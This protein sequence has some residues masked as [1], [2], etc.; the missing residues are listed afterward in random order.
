MKN[1]V[2]RKRAHKE[3][4][5]EERGWRRG[6]RKKGLKGK[7]VRRMRMEKKGLNVE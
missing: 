3:E 1:K 4:K 7:G 5:I 6:K 2:R